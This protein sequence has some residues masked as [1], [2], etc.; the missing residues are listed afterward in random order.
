MNLLLLCACDV[1]QRP[2]GPMETLACTR[3]QRLSAIGII[4]SFMPGGDSGDPG[5]S[6]VGGG[7]ETED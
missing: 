4:D 5:L 3:C 6:R 2:F 7:R 1:L